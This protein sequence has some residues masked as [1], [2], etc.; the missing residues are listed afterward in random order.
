MAI[1]KRIACP[2][3]GALE[4]EARSAVLKVPGV[5]RVE[6]KMSANVKKDRRLES[7][8]PPGIKN[9]IAVEEV[10]VA[11]LATGAGH[12]RSEHPSMSHQPKKHR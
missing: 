12:E 11:H 6:I 3:K 9:V 7:I 5:K 1:G 10:V 2:L 8:L 4:D